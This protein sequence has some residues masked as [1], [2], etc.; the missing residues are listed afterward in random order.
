[1]LGRDPF[2]PALDS[3]LAGETINGSNVVA[4]RISQ[5]EQAANCHILF[6]SSSETDQLKQ[7]LPAL[8]KM[9]VLTVSDIPQFER[10]G[11]MIEFVMD[12]NKVR[13]EVNLASAERAGLSLSSQLLKVAL[14]VRTGTQPK[15]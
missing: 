4:K 5:P 9:S 1:V 15:V 14:R 11:G 3:T 12:G 6:I 13:F 7:L 2:G 10:H 8:E